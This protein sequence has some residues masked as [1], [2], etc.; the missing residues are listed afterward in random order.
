MLGFRARFSLDIY[1]ATGVV[2]LLISSIALAFV[3]ISN[4]GLIAI[5]SDRSNYLLI[6]LIASATPLAMLLLYLFN[7]RGNRIRLGS[8]KTE[9]IDIDSIK[10]N[11]NII[12]I[13]EQATTKQPT[14]KIDKEI[15]E[16]KVET[17]SIGEQKKEPIEQTQVL[18]ELKTYTAGNAK[19]D[20]EGVIREEVTKATTDLISKIDGFSQEITSVKKE[21]EEMKSAVENAMIDIRS[22]LSE[23]SN[24]LNYMRRFVTDEEIEELGLNPGQGA[25]VNGGERK[26]LLTETKKNH[27]KEPGKIVEHNSNS[28]NT[29]EV[30]IESIDIDNFSKELAEIFS[31]KMSVSKLMRMII[32]IGDNLSILGRDGLLGLVELGVSSGVIPKES[33]DI[34]AKVVSLIERTKIPPKRLALTLHKLAKSIGVSDRE[35][36]FLAMALSEG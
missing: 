10:D 12:N 28:Q 35:A 4:W 8:E 23:I 25:G 33:M 18:E 32:F 13:E 16:I 19:I 1:T 36:E 20:I 26:K 2:V 30:S 9:K 22:L 34:V 21:L 17:V 11:I 5:D 27:I 6:I 14:E 31:K 15:K 3:V 29:E 7:I 24:P